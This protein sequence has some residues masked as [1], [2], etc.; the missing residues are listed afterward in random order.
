LARSHG[1]YATAE[2]Y[3]VATMCVGV[4]M[5]MAVVIENLAA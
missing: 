1:S 2:G 4:G 3:G 5:G